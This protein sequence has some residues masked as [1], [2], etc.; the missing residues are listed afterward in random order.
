[1][2]WLD[3]AQ[4]RAQR[5]R[6]ALYPLEVG[7]VVAVLSSGRVLRVNCWGS[8][9]DLPAMDGTV[10]AVNDRVVV[11]RSGVVSVVLGRVRT[12]TGSTQVIPDVLWAKAWGVANQTIQCVDAAGTT[13]G[14]WP[15]LA[16][17]TSP[18]LL[19][20]PS[21]DRV[22]VLASGPSG[23]II[24]GKLAVAPTLPPSAAPAP[25]V[26]AAPAAPEAGVDTFTATDARS[27]R[28]GKWRTDSSV[29]A[30]HEWGGF[31][32]NTGAWFYGTA[33]GDL[34]RGATVTR[35]Q[36]F[37]RRRSGGT[38]GAQALH[39]YRHGSTSRPA[40][41]VTSLAGPTDTTLDIGEGRWVDLPA[42]WGQ[43]IVDT[44]GGLMIAG[45]PYLVLDG[46]DA[47]PAS[48]SLRLDWSRTTT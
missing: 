3:V 4:E 10:Y 48:G 20:Y 42:S 27:F 28:N 40:G 23:P 34:L 30:Q 7:Q 31:G 14:P 21:G 33:P 37:V 15:Y 24:L 45:A 2:D 8:S 44:G 46:L 22:A 39:L 12:S 1:M 47:D 17:Y 43:A 9:E 35:T 5:E 32:V 38:S 29:V 26:S 16:S 41:V 18:S 25:V 11:A 36:V 19:G 13:Y 6:A